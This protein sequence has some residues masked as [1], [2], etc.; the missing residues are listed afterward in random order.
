MPILSKPLVVPQFGHFNSA[1]TQAEPPCTVN[2]FLADGATPQDKYAIDLTAVFTQLKIDPTLYIPSPNVCAA[3]GADLYVAISAYAGVG[4]NVPAAAIL[5]F[6][7]Y[8]TGNNT[9]ATVVASVFTELSSGYCGLAFDGGANLYAVENNGGI[10][11]IYAYPITSSGSVRTPILTTNIQPSPSFFGDIAFDASGNLW[12]AD[13]NN[14]SILAFPQANLGGTNAYTIVTGGTGPFSVVNK[15]A[16]L[17]ATK[18]LYIFASPEGVGFDGSGN[19][20][21][22]NNNDG[23]DAGG[24]SNTFTSLVQVT[25]SLLS[26][27]ISAASATGAT[28]SLAPSKAL[29]LAQVQSAAPPAGYAIYQVPTPLPPTDYMKSPQF[30]GLQ[31]DMIG[32]TDLAAGKPQYLYVNDEIGNTVQQFDINPNSPTFLAAIAAGQS[33]A[34]TLDDAGGNPVVTNPGNGGIALVYPRLLIADYPTTDTGA[35]PDTTLPTDGE[36]NPIFWESQG[37]GVGTSAT[38]PVDFSQDASIGYSATGA[39][40]YVSVQNIGCTPTTGTEQ[41]RLYWA[42]GAL[43][44]SWPEPWTE[45]PTSPGNIGIVGAGGSTVVTTQWSTMPDPALYGMNSHWCLLARIETQP[46]Y[47]FGMTYWEKNQTSDPGDPLLLSYNVVSN[48]KIAQRNI[49]I[50]VPG[51]IVGGL[52]GRGLGG[53]RHFPFTSGIRAGNFGPKISRTKIGFQLLNEA[54]R[55]ISL[56]ESRLVIHAEGPVLDKLL[57]RKRDA[58]EY[59][60]EGAFHLWQPEKGF[61]EISLR[62]GETLPLTIDFTPPHSLSDYALRV[63]Q[64]DEVDGKQGLVG[65][66]TFVFGKVAGFTVKRLTPPDASP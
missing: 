57:E 16:S 33:F 23:E 50:G 62:P 10:S 4:T 26:S 66:Q 18:P 56:A 27:I 39:Y 35:E 49:Y 5:K 59:L 55:P 37:I 48:S 15:D 12:V 54:A 2:L 43:S 46:V 42:S 20:W 47:P 7:G 22:G 19:L 8:F 53:I 41:L 6:T 29:T 34:L 36:G 21:V 61:D 60:G 45:I 11:Q 65:G 1:Y 38:P 63:M 58:A 31:I 32:P 30:G 24:V 3:A 28:F 25:P 13:Y 64:Y 9:T 44:Q 40:I 52:G 14:H 17:A 51:K